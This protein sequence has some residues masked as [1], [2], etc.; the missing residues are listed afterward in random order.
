MRPWLAANEGYYGPPLSEAARL[1]LVHWLGDH[2]YDGYAYS[3][4]DDPF[5]RD[6]WRDPYPA[7]DLEHFA[8]LH[9]VCDRAGV[10]LILMM[11][12]GLDWRVGE[13]TEIDALTAKFQAFHDLGVRALSINWDDVPGSGAELGAEHGSAV[14]AVAERVGPDVSW[15]A[16]PIDYAIDEPS[17]Y[18]L[19]FADA[20][21]ADVPVAWTGPSVLSPH[22]DP[23]HVR[24]LRDRLGRD[25]WLA[26]NFP[27][28]D[29]VMSDVLHL[30]P[31]PERDAELIGLFAGVSLNF[32]EHPQ[33]SRI[34]LAAAARFWHNGD[35]DRHAAWRSVL[36]EQAPALE[37]LA[38]ACRS[39]LGDA[40][41]DPT[42]L[43]WLAAAVAGD[44]AALRSYLEA[45]CRTGL[46]A[47][48][49]AEVEPWL[50]QWEL[51]AEAMLAALDLSAGTWPPSI[52]DIWRGGIAWRTARL[53]RPQVFGLRFAMYPSTQHSDTG[54]RA[55]EGVVSVGSNLTDALWSEVLSRLDP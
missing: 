8:A 38:M 24:R 16:C 40:G 42:L 41:P 30:G 19:A 44:D 55:A 52:R 17:D 14:A 3:P 18:L 7:A 15:R 23:G 47:D 29:L 53:G 35:A 4:K 10:D 37:P 50:A 49:V 54:F 21:P 12:P 39:W 27:V 34:G 1:D 45:G 32:M 22:I 6:R 20:L 31:Y 51:E 43:E 28:N 33:A 26:D 13:G 11:S 2:G 36:A 9:D 25:L 5:H 46:P 48:L